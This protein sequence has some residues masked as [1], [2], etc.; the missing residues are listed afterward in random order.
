MPKTYKSEHSDFTETTTFYKKT[1][2][3]L[4]GGVFEC[5]TSGEF[6]YMNTFLLKAFGQSLE[7]CQNLGWHK[8]IHPNDLEVILNAW[9]RM[10]DTGRSFSKEIKICST[11]G[12]I[13][14]VSMHVKPVYN[15]DSGLSGFTGFVQDI[16]NLKELGEKIRQERN[17]LHSIINNSPDFIY[18]K[19]C[20]LKTFLCNEICAA[21]LGKKPEELYGKT[22]MENGWEEKYV[23]GDMENGIRGYIHDDL[24]VL[25]GLV[26]R[27]HKDVAIVDG[28]EHYFDT[29]KYPIRNDEGDVIGILGVSRNV[30]EQV[31]DSQRLWHQANHDQLTTMLNRASFIDRLKEEI[32]KGKRNYNPFALLFIDLDEFKQINDSYG[33]DIGDMLLVDVSKKISHCIRTT[34]IIARFGGDEFVVLMPNV[35]SPSVVERLCKSILDEFRQPFSLGKHTVFISISIG[36]TFYPEDSDSMDFLLKFSDKAMYE[37]KNLG[38]NKY[39]FFKGEDQKNSIRHQRLE[40]DYNSA[41]RDNRLIFSEIPIIDITTGHHVMSDAEA[42][43]NH[44]TEGRI[45]NKDVVEISESSNLYAETEKW[46]FDSSLQKL[47]L[48]GG[49]TQSNH[50]IFLPSSLARLRRTKMLDWNNEEF[51]NS[52]AQPYSGIV[53]VLN[54]KQFPAR[55]EGIKKQLDK[56]RNLGVKISLGNFG[57]ERSSFTALQEF[58]IDFVRVGN[59]II[60]NITNNNKERALCDAL[61]ALAHKLEIKVIAVGVKDINQLHVLKTLGCDY[62]QGPYFQH[63]TQRHN[64]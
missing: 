23:L 29:V 57:A 35:S 54:E 63:K 3:N 1:I 6:I 47:A 34:D 20:N 4:P 64:K 14:H 32:E 46:I 7:Q 58:N 12:K 2:D 13:F 5:D 9:H 19:D 27:T 38:R 41:L 16:T 18:A 52:Q 33:H 62:A 26:T 61:I 10:L 22:D 24:D 15:T 8:S 59:N 17:L 43:W 31:N 56:Y 42:L 60:E 37:A 55:M 50:K 51:Q 39:V 44:P 25:K 28:Q 40:N 53:I 48:L 30:T 45:N 21:S 36:I 11:N 49:K